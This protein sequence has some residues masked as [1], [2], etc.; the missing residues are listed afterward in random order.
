M[1]GWDTIYALNI[2]NANQA[3][4][5]SLSK[6]IPTVQE[7]ISGALGDYAV[8]VEFGP[9]QIALGGS[10]QLINLQVPI[11]GGSITPNGGKPVSLKGMT[12]MFSVSLKLLAGGPQMQELCFDFA[13]AGTLGQPAAAGVVVPMG[14]VGPAPDPTIGAL[15]LNAI[16][17][18]LV[19]QAAKL[20]FAFAQINL[21]PPGTNSWLAPC[22]LNYAFFNNHNGQAFLAILSTTGD[23]SKLPVTVDPQ[24][25]AGGTAGFAFSLPLFFRNCVI[26][27]MVATLPDKSTA[28]FT[29]NANVPPQIVLRNGASV[30]LGGVKVGAIN[31]YPSMD[32]FTA[33]PGVNQMQVS[34]SGGCDV[35]AGLSMSWNAQVTNQFVFNAQNQTIEFTASASPSVNHDIHIPWYWWTIA[36][37]ITGIADG[38]AT[39]I[40]NGIASFIGG[41]VGAGLMSAAPPASIQFAG[42]KQFHV[43]GAVFDGAVILTG[44][45]GN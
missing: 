9:W 45:P 20:A 29:L 12:P 2:A 43:T 41:R 15:T 1:N 17:T 27:G 24:L 6:L 39:L 28:S 4:A 21:V 25:T 3:L 32:S 40:G 26:P 22:H 19:A 44:Q 35:Y 42:M 8:S 14:F 30:G 5:N 37:V 31:Y 36:P 33:T 11:A 34:V 23:A 7:R 16:A 18:G 38:V 10:S 13:R